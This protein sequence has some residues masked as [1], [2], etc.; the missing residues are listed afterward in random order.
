MAV[1]RAK[2][3]SNDFNVSSKQKKKPKITASKGG[4]V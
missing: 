2:L 1:E 3:E 4:Q